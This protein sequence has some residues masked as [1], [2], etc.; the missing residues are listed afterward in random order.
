MLTKVSAS[1]GRWNHFGARCRP[2]AAIVPK[3]VEM[4]AVEIATMK[5]FS[6]ALWMT[7]SPRTL[8]YHFRLKPAHCVT[9]RSVPLKLNTTT[10]TIGM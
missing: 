3:T 5:L 2:S 4:I 7:L 10:T 9:T 8:A 6:S 1:N